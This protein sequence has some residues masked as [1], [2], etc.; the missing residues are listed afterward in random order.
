MNPSRYVETQ[1]GRVIL[2][3]IGVVAFCLGSLVILGWLIGKESLINI[4]SSY[5]PMKIYT[6]ISF[7]LIG[8]ALFSILFKQKVFGIASCIALLIISIFSLYEYYDVLRESSYH[9]VFPYQLPEHIAEKMHMGPNT[10]ICL[11]LIGVSLLLMNFP[12]R[13]VTIFFIQLAAGAISAFSM[14]AL[15]GYFTG[16]ISL[17]GWS[18][19]SGMAL[20]T[21]LGLL[22]IG[23]GL[24]LYQFHL[25]YPQAKVSF[26]A[27][28]SVVFF[29]LTL[30]FFFWQSFRAQ[31]Y[32][33]LLRITKVSAIYIVDNFKDAL[34]QTD[35]ALRRLA[36]R[37][38]I[39]SQ[40]ESE[41]W[42]E[43]SNAFLEDLPWVMSLGIYDNQFS[44]QKSTS[45]SSNLSEKIKEKLQATGKFAFSD[46]E[47][48]LLMSPLKQNHLIAEI[49]ISSMIQKTL[50]NFLLDS[51]EF[52]ILFDNVRVYDNLSALSS[53]YVI[54][55]K[56]MEEFNSVIGDWSI[57]VFPTKDL[58]N[59]NQKNIEYFLIITGLIVTLFSTLAMLF[60]RMA[61]QA[62]N[63]LKSVLKD[64]EEEIAYKQA[65][66]DSSAYSIIATE[67]SG[68]ISIFNRAAERMLGYK[69]EEMINKHTPE[70]FHDKEEM[71]KRA[72]ELSVPTGFDVFVE[73]AKQ[74]KNEERE[75]TYINKDGSRFPVMLSV[76]PVKDVHGIL[77]G[78]VGIA[79]D[80]TQY[81]IAEKMKNELISITSHELRSP[82]AAVRSSLNLINPTSPQEIQVL[83]IA[84]RNCDRLI[85]LTS[86][87]LDI[88]KMEAGKMDY[89]FK[90]L[91]LPILIK[92]SIEANQP[93]AKENEIEIR[94]QNDPPDV[95]IFGDQDRLM[96]VL[97][98]LISNAIKY[99]PKGSAILFNFSQS[100]RK[101][102]IGVKD[103]GPEIPEGYIPQ[104]FQKFT[105]LPGGKKGTG[106]GLSI[107]KA[108]VLRH[109]G[110]IG[111]ETSP[112]GNTFWFEL[113]LD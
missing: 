87:I 85:S 82:I 75:W 13:T 27:L 45:T 91:Q 77:L 43:E 86:D 66:L 33:N 112:Q 72:Q 49:D 9:F 30:I 101:V 17:V 84:K 8:L 79:Y 102:R 74:G 104:L 89:L 97:N 59:P 11:F 113:P 25:E 88:Q 20:H 42:K 22:L 4:S 44:L 61:I 24:F 93:L 99:S 98:N 80:L 14:G 1:K 48:L 78:F 47:H 62:K 38:E 31:E 16:L 7:F 111:I 73:L 107:A 46:E 26:G 50:P 90:E 32:F 103:Q 58:Q 2:W 63:Q 19:F 57:L 70:V 76:N 95:K 83:D 96:Q 5:P 92:Q 67:Y 37:M 34:E 15:F 108:I 100:D 60:A 71:A 105:Q 36:K 68:K 54:G 81:K 21:A 51:Y 10:A 69:A 65:I 110:T 52:Y 18:Y 6:A 23:I 35:T 28:L 3:F 55:K 94:C 40:N 29:S 56:A 12:P 106:L 64:K 109:N 53:S 41:L 39:S